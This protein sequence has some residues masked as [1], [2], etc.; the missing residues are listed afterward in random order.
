MSQYNFLWKGVGILFWFSG[1]QEAKSSRSKKRKKKKDIYFNSSFKNI[2]DESKKPN[3]SFYRH[4]IYNSGYT[5]LVKFVTCLKENT[6]N[7]TWHSND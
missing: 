7:F 2:G 6:L 3:M 4:D 5:T 1:R